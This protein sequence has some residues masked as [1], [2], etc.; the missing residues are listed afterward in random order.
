MRRFIGEALL[1]IIEVICIILDIYLWPI[2]WYLE[3]SEAVLASVD[4]ETITVKVVRVMTKF[5]SW[6]YKKVRGIQDPLEELL[7]KY[8]Y[9][10]K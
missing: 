7:E 6:F 4:E 1:T 9:S 10:R 5:D 3:F 2:K 8:R